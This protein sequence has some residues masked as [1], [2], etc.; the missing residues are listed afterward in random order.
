MLVALVEAATFGQPQWTG[1]DPSVTHKNSGR[2]GDKQ[3]VPS[4]FAA[5]DA[6]QKQPVSLPVDVRNQI[7]LD[8]GEEAVGIQN[9]LRG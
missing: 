1:A 9:P 2:I 5:C 6:D 4:G 7:G 8:I 3:V